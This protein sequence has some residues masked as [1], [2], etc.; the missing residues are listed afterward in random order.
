M[1]VKDRNRNDNFVSP[2]VV[3]IVDIKRFPIY[4]LVHKSTDIQPNTQSEHAN[5]RIATWI[6][7]TRSPNQCCIKHLCAFLFLLMVCRAEFTTDQE[8]NLRSFLK[9][10]Y[11][12]NYSRAYSQTTACIIECTLQTH[13]TIKAKHIFESYVNG[14]NENRRRW[15][16]L[17]V[18]QLGQVSFWKGTHAFNWIMGIPDSYMDFDH[19]NFSLRP[20]R[21]D[22][23]GVVFSIVN[24]IKKML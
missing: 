20:A 15:R 10:V 6:S 19:M 24:Q 11:T 9:E 22:D 16:S 23:R 3:N 8:I 17:S 12:S 1:Y 14:R 13:S 18:H 5:N 21:I 7:E 2:S 4:Y